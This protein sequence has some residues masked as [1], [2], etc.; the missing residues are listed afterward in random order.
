MV[1]IG[2]CVWYHP[3]RRVRYSQRTV[4]GVILLAGVIGI[5]RG[6]RVRYS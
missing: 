4:F 1:F 3:W 5:T 2:R 6:R